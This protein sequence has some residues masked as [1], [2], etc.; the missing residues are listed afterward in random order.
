MRACVRESHCVFVA[1]GQKPDE[2]EEA[3]AAAKKQADEMAA[4]I[5]AVEKQAA[6]GRAAERAIAMTAQQ[7]SI[8]SSSGQA[9]VFSKELADLKVWK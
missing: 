9:Q 1:I 4:A 6:E 7:N 3:S 8:P 2:A 5:A